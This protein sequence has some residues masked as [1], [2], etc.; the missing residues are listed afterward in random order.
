MCAATYEA[1]AGDYPAAESGPLQLKGK[2]SMVQGF[3]IRID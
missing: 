3:R 1:V 2:R